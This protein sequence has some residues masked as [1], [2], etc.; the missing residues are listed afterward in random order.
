MR[1]RCAKSR[2]AP[3]RATAIS[4]SC[5]SPGDIA[6]RPRRPGPARCRAMRARTVVVERARFGL[7]YRRIKRI[8][9]AVR[10]TCGIVRALRRILATTSGRPR[11]V[12]PQVFIP[13][14][15]T[16][17][18]PGQRAAEAIAATRA[19]RNAIRGQCQIGFVFRRRRR[20]H[21]RIARHTQRPRIRRIER[22]SFHGRGELHAASANTHRMPVITSRGTSLRAKHIGT[23]RPLGQR[24]ATRSIG[25]GNRKRTRKR[26]GGRKT[27]GMIHQRSK[28]GDVQ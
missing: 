16:L 7:R 20:C 17:F 8:R 10:T 22:A 24:I 4:R 1:P 19:E 27:E 2:S 28:S 3:G 21:E 6:R 11:A 12:G 25:C 14:L 15:L 18:V 5:A 26:G 23:C 13:V 9:R